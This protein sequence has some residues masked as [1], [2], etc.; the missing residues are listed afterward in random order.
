MLIKTQNL[1]MTPDGFVILDRF[2]EENN[3]KLDNRLNYTLKVDKIRITVSKTVQN[4]ILI[5][6]IAFE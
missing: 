6:E 4:W 5:S 2:K 1:T 3:G